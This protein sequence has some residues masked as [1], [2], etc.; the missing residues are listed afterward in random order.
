MYPTLPPYHDPSRMG[1]MPQP[2]AR[3]GRYDPELQMYVRE[4][5][6]LDMRWLRFLRWLAEHGRAD[7][8]VQGAPV[9]PRA[10]DVN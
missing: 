9:M 6:E 5:A 10:E 1:Q 4:P 3:Y 7:S 8:P 2:H